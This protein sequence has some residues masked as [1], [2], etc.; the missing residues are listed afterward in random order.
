[1]LVLFRFRQ[2]H[3][4]VSADIERMF[5][6]ID[7]LPEDQPSLRFMWREDP[8]ADVVVHQYT[9]H[10]F[11]A[12]DSQTCVNYALQRIAMDNQAKLPDAA[13]AV[14]K[15]FYIDDY[16]D[17]FED[18]DV[19]INLSQEFINVLALGG[20]K[21]SKFIRNLTKFNKTLSP[22]QSAPQQ[23]SKNIVTCGDNSSDVLV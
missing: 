10:I 8:T 18:P 14:L 20:F 22:P 16:L 3:F 6:Q 23:E 9:R 12:R 15:K 19:A 5:L 11:G 1:M 17:S 4:A 7:D 2:H 13:S 21:I